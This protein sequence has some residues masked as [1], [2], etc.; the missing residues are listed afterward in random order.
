MTFDELKGH[1]RQIWPDR[2][3]DLFSWEL[4]PI[5]EVLPDFLVCRI[6]PLTPQ[7]PWVYVTIGAS[8]IHIG[9]S[10]SIEFVLLAPDDNA[11][12]IETLAIVAYYQATRKDKLNVG[13]V[14][15][16]GRPW[17]G[18]STC[19]HLL[20]SLPYPFGPSLEWYHTN[21]GDHVRFLWLLPITA[22]EATYAS[23]CGIESLERRFDECEIDAIDPCRQAVA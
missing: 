15:N 22:S 19:E 12:H 23:A 10:Y 18:N 11:R 16:C 1:L 21:K 20:V 13:R 2:S 7:E 6:A 3:M 4:G 8:K 9:E 17:L 5:N 14:V